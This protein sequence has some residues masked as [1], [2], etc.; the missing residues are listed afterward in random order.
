MNTASFVTK[1]EFFEGLDMLAQR[2]ETKIDSKIDGIDSGLNAKLDGVDSRLNARIDGL[3]RKI[4]G[5]DVRM[6]ARIDNLAE[7]VAQGFFDVDQKLNHLE[8]TKANKTDIH[9]LRGDVRRGFED[10]KNEMAM[11][12]SDVYDQLSYK[13][14]TLADFIGFS[15]PRRNQ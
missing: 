2:I 11:F 13:V 4:E 8:E 15:W 6:N 12:T 5:L 3:D 7:V 1:K 14:N 10:S 9:D